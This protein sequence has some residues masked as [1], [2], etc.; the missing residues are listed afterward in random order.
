M[1]LSTTQLRLQGIGDR[2]RDLAFDGK[3]VRE[4]PIVRFRP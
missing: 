3:N 4:L 2:F 1:L